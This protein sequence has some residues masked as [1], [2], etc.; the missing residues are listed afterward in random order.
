LRVA[1]QI[2]DE[3]QSYLAYTKLRDENRSSKGSIWRRW[4]EEMFGSPLSKRIVV[5]G[6]PEG[7]G[8]GR[9]GWSARREKERRV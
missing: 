7:G 8:V 3:R 9:E 5:W 6:R 2:A 1:S 4:D